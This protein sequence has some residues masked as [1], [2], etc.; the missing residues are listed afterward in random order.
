MIKRIIHGLALFLTT[1]LCVSVQAQ[2]IEVSLLTCG[3]G[4][5]LYSTFGHTAIRVRDKTNNTDVVYDYGVFDFNDPYFM[6]KFLSGKLDYYV[7]RRSFRQFI[8]EYEDLGRGVEEQILLLSTRTKVDITKALEENLKPENRTYKYDFLKDNCSTRA[9]DIILQN[10]EISQFAKIKSRETY[11]NYL[12]VYLKDKAWLELGIDLLLGTE[13]DGQLDDFQKMFLPNSLS[14]GLAIITKSDGNPLVQQSTV[15]LEENP[16]STSTPIKPLHLA[17][18]VSVAF[19]G[20]IFFYPKSVKT[21]HLLQ[22]ISLTSAGLFLLYMWLGTD[23]SATKDN[24]NI[25]WA[26]PYYLFFLLLPKKQLKY[27]LLG[28]LTLINVFALLA[29]PNIPQSLNPICV[30]ILVTPTCL[31]VKIIYDYIQTK[32]GRNIS[33]KTYTS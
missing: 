6:F 31:N 23:H 10:A 11:R 24:W 26:N 19:I 7:A 4:K 22:A 13:A 2:E 18:L 27:A 21:L 3:P 16:R 12:D 30:L 28:G 17:V 32:K 1:V 29:W 20:C 15:L 5:A 33:P 8:A 25:L 14:N 9:R